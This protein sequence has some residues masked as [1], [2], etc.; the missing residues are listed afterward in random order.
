MKNFETATKKRDGEMP[1]KIISVDNFLHISS[2]KKYIFEAIR[3]G[4]KLLIPR[5]KRKKRQ[6]APSSSTSEPT[7][8]VA[9]EANPELTARIESRLKSYIDDGR[10][11]VECA[12]IWKEEEERTGSRSD[13]DTKGD[14]QLQ[15][16]NTADN[17]G[18]D[19]GTSSDQIEIKDGRIALFVNSED[20]EWASVY[21]SIGGRF[22]TSYTKISVQM[23]TMRELYEKY[24]NPDY[25]KIDIEGADGVCLDQLAALILTKS[26]SKSSSRS[27]ARLPKYLSF[28]CNSLAW[29]D[30][31]VALGYRCFKLVLT[32]TN[33]PTY[34][35][36]ADLSLLRIMPRCCLFQSF[37]SF[38]PLF[39][40]KKK[41]KKKKEQ[42]RIVRSLSQSR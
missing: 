41:K 11:V 3:E 42:Q 14:D 9:V 28:E 23:T 26:S 38:L 13:Y 35:P 37:Q 15:H 27:N 40:N 39:N 16:C 2:M 21:E 1:S 34:L 6:A 33:L 18:N 12:A 17:G 7:W 24:G 5:K 36:T 20:C 30:K 22:N 25:V 31:A 19:T 29:I 4:A 32:Y 10:L 8:V